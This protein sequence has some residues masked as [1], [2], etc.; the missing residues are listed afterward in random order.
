MDLPE[1]VRRRVL[2]E[3]LAPRGADLF[4]GLN[5]RLPQ[6]PYRRA[7]ATFHDL[8]VM[9]G[10]YST[11][12]VPR[13]VHGAGAGRGGAG[14]RDHRGLRVHEEPGGL[15]SRCG[16]GAGSRSASRNSTTAADR[17]GARAGDSERRGDSET[18][19][20]RAAGGGVRDAWT[21]DGGWCLPARTGTAPKRFWRGLQRARR[22][23]EFKSQVTFH[24]HNWR[25]GTRALRSSLFPRGRR[26]RHA[27]AGSDGRRDTGGHLR[28][29]PRCPKSPA[30]RRCWWIRRARK[31]CAPPCGT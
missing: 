11:R 24:L 13:A 16:G 21:A 20:Y 2:L 27:G 19:E 6:L 12:G 28:T 4:H 10:E 30:T 31:R 3:P 5:Q 14:R 9:T 1:N 22:A 23:T 26:L 15:A 8:F 25:N 7:I 18:Q 29:A 17:S